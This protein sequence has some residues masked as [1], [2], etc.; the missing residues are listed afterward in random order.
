ML[1]RSVVIKGA[2]S[3][4]VHG[5]AVDRD[6][7]VGINAVGIPGPHGDGNLPAVDL[8][9]SGHRGG[10]VRGVDPV[11]G[12]GDPHNAAVDLDKGP[13]KPLGRGN[14]Q[15]PVIDLHRRVPVDAVAAGGDGQ[16]PAAEIDLP[17]RVV[18]V[19]AR[20]Q[21]VLLRGNGDLPAGHRDGVVGLQAVRGAPNDQG[22]AGDLQ[23]VL[24]GYAVVG[25]FN[26][27]GPRAVEHQ[28]VPGENDRVA[29]I[30]GKG[31]GHG[32]AAL[33]FGGGD[34]HLVGVLYPDAGLAVIGDG[35][36]VQHQLDLVVVPGVHHNRR[37]PGRTAENIDAGGGDLQVLSVAHRK[38]RRLREVRRLL[39]VPV[40]K[41]VDLAALDGFGLRRAF[42]CGC[43]RLGCDR[44]PGGLGRQLGF[45]FLGRGPAGGQRAGQ[46]SGQKQG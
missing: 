38:V 2:L 40:R 29:A 42:F 30:P 10:L 43:A 39:Q 28:V 20:I 7:A 34:K 23:V 24:G 5:A 21:P 4:N 19:V 15:G 16:G 11:V 9:R 13:L 37:V 46:Q 41:P 22:P 33:P 31:P 14:G 1:R 25:G 27:Q 17:R 44:L 3:G 35:Q 6:I 8:H 45:R 32:Q 36:A 18:L 26:G 12:G